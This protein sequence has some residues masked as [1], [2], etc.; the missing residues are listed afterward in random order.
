[1]KMNELQ[2]RKL[3]PFFLR[4]LPDYLD[5][6][7][8]ELLDKNNLREELENITKMKDARKVRNMKT[9]QVGDDILLEFDV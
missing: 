1:M 5:K 9:S 8:K 4:E 3:R 6:K 2:R 7:I